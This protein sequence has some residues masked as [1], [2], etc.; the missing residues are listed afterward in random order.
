MTRTDGPLVELR[1]VSVSYAGVPVLSGVDAALG[2]GE[3]V[4]VTGDNGSGK[5]SLLRVLSG[6]QR[7]TAGMRVARTGARGVRLMPQAP[8]LAWNLP[9][10]TNIM[11][12]LGSRADVSWWPALL[13]P[14]A[15]TSRYDELRSAAE[16]VLLRFGLATKAQTRA[17][18]LSG[19]ERKLLAVAIA[20][21]GEARV[22][23]LDE[24]FAGLSPA[25]SND[26]RSA[27]A[28][29]K[30]AQQTV[31]IVEHRTK[32][33]ADL[34]DHVWH[35]DQG[36]LYVRAPT[37]PADAP[38]AAHASVRRS[39]DAEHGAS[40]SDS[41]LE[42][43]ALRGGWNSNVVVGDATFRLSRG[44][45][46]GVMGENGVGK[47]T[48]IALLCGIIQPSGG[49]MLLGGS[50]V[51]QAATH[52]RVLFGLRVLLQT[53][54]VFGKLSVEENLRLGGR[55]KS[56]NHVLPIRADRRRLAAT[57]S[58]GEQTI[59]GIDVATCD[60]AATVVLLDEPSAG[61]DHVARARVRKRILALRE[62][63]IACLVVDHDRVF[64]EEL[65]GRILIF[66]CGRICDEVSH[67]NRKDN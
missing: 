22:V 46:A 24:P 66:E 1:S 55:T 15:A 32:H 56:T 53:R 61:L 39:T 49:R 30:A 45:T 6:V 47:S 62:A 63:G 52:E 7:P 25:A 51:T 29:A 4:L 31:V 57:L 9:L 13:R 64:L 34:A 38:A 44:A 27:I 43:R 50:D 23:L 59:L 26:V 41:A 10:D 33:T 11:L 14:R 28:R 16:S 20:F 8:R 18:E 19:G 37:A 21:A 65:S 48:F 58:G 60:E 42:V 67:R 17:M 36:E 5:S 3:C 54:R 35:V 12:A 40:R 2:A